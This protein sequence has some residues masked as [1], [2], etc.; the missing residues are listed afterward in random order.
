MQVT[1]KAVDLAQVLGSLGRSSSLVSE[2]RPIAFR[3]VEGLLL[4]GVVGRPMSYALD[5]E[6]GNTDHDGVLPIDAVALLMA[7]L[8][9]HDGPARLGVA[10]VGAERAKV[11]SVRSG[12]EALRLECQ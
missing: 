3:A 4:V 5:V 7:F 12:V 6:V 2:T 11:L 10:R 1:V 8:E 9:R